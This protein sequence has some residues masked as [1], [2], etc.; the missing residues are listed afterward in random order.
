ML[1]YFCTLAPNGFERY[2]R[3]AVP[4]QAPRSGRANPET[5]RFVYAFLLTIHPETDN[6]EIRAGISILEGMT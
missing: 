2:I 6:A 4:Q 1:T 3:R 5:L